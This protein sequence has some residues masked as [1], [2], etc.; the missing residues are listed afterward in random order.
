MR[1][2]RRGQR[3]IAFG[4]DSFLDVVA[5]VVGIIL[6]LILVAWIGA[7][8]YQAML[9]VPPPPPPPVFADP[10]PLPE[11]T[12]ER[13]P[14]LAQRRQQLETLRQQLLRQSSREP[15]LT[16]LVHRLQTDLQTVKQQRDQLAASEQQQ[17]EAA[18]LQG[19]AAT[20]TALSIEELQAR[21]KKLTEEIDKI[22]KMP[23]QSKELR[24]RTPVSAEVQTEEMMF[25]CRAGKVALIDHGTMLAE[26]QREVRSKEKELRTRWEVTDVTAPVGAFRLRYTV[27]RERS[28]LDVPGAAPTDG[29]FRYGVTRWEVVP[30]RSD[31]GETLEQALA[32]GSEFRRI[33]DNA[34]PQQTAITFWV[35]PDSFALFRRLRDY[36]YEKDFIV[37]GRPLPDGVPIASSRHGTVTRGQ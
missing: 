24:Y 4:F 31:R 19:I 36:L 17:R 29:L 7:R 22:G 26:I 37:A 6:R 3:E 14:L 30:I 11:P 27:E 2:R 25:E 15:Q 13:L 9:P 10:E 33:V 16:E 12:D 8:T 34:E 32:S 21:S 5:N 28:I 23:R 18:Q 1:R 35:Y 20:A